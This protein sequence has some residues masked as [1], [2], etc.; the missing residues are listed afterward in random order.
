MTIHANICN[1]LQKEFDVDNTNL[2]SDDTPV[3]NDNNR[4]SS[5]SSF[6]VESA[7]S[8]PAERMRIDTT[9]IEN[10]DEGKGNYYF[11]LTPL[12]STSSQ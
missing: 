2:Y 10:T 9:A 12:Q 6:V 11:S 8:M 7:N 3:I 5:A 4:I 1:I